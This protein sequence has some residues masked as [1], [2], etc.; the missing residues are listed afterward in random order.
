MKRKEQIKQLVNQTKTVVLVECVNE[1]FNSWTRM[2]GLLGKKEYPN[3]ALVIHP[4]QQVHTWFM[5][6]P[7]DLIFIDP[8]QKV[9]AKEQNV[10]PWSL[11]KKRRDAVAVIE[12]EIGV[13]SDDKVTIG[14]VLTIEKVDEE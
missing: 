9:I 13:F 1:A 7:I 5:R 6:F 8:M 4:C 14:D 12:A 2:K 11:S 3:Q 10:K